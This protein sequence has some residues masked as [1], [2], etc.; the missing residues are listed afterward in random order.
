MIKIRKAR[1]A[2]ANRMIQVLV[3]AYHGNY[4]A[5]G[6]YYSRQE[7]VDPNYQI[8]SGP[9]NSREVFVR[10][11]VKSLNKRL[12]SPFE[13]FVMF[14]DN[15]MIGYII[16][17]NHLGRTWINDIIIKKNY[18]NKDL[19]RKLFLHAT[20]NKKQIYLW[21]N[22]KNPAFKFWKKMGFNEVLKECLMMKK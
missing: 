7:L 14:D 1:L 15:D 10:E 19:G 5:A 9:Y 4:S 17:E 12:K 11:N 8:T 20:K 22:M 3:D 2:D 16:I 18:Q 13:A 6:E 21:V